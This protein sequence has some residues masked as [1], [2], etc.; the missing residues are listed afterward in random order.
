MATTF[1]KNGT[2]VL[3]TIGANDPI[4]APG[5]AFISPHPS[6]ADVIMISE[7]FNPQNREEALKIYVSEVTVPVATD[8]KDLIEQLSTDFF[9]RVSG[10]GVST[11]KYNQ[12]LTGLQNDVNTVYSTP[13]Q[14]I[15]GGSQ[16]FQNGGLLTFGIDYTEVNVGGYG[17]GITVAIALSA[18]AVLR[19]NYDKK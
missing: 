10:T 18:D 13:D 15:L 4:S 2:N 8:R 19:I 3:V 14:F 6:E 7:K 1:V 17:T 12:S 9:F 5:N 11:R 16:V